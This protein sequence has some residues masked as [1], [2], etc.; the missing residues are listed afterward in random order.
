MGT[1]E[2]APAGLSA[3]RVAEAKDAAD[4]RCRCCRAV[5]CRLV[6]IGATV[7]LGWV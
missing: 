3:C 6:L 2:S 4:W 1:A 5:D 7:G